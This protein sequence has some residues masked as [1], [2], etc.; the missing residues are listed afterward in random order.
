MG[1]LDALIW[2]LMM[3]HPYFQFMDTIAGIWFDYYMNAWLQLYYWPS[4]V[5]G[6]EDE[7]SQLISKM[8]MCKV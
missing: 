5:A 6:K 7:M 8:V 3:T 1:K 4:F 2:D